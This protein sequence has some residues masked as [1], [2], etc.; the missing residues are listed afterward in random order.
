MKTW[1]KFIASMGAIL[2]VLYFTY[3][4]G[5]TH[6]KRVTWLSELLQRTQGQPGYLIN[7][8]VSCANGKQLGPLQVDLNL[9]NG[10]LRVI[11]N[12][13][14]PMPSCELNAPVQPQNPG[15]PAVPPPAVPAPPDPAGAKP[16]AK[17]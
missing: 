10:K 8:N 12:D 13:A 2:G 14:G 5:E 16:P 7:V 3:S 17:K 9:T 1:M 15:I 6:A 4:L 11:R